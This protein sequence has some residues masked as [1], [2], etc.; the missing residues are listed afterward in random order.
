MDLLSVLTWTG[1]I[2]CLVLA[3]TGLVPVIAA[4]ATFAAIPFHAFVN[5]YRKAEP[6]LPRVAIVV[7]AWNE[8]AV[9]GASIDR[10]MQLE[11]P[12]EALRI[13]VV[14]DAST[15]ATPDV[16]REKA[17]LYPGSVVLL[18]RDKGGE[19]KAHTLNHGITEILKDDWMEALLIMDADVIYLPDSLRRM[20]RHLADPEVGAVSAY[21]REGSADRNYLTKFIAVEYVLS[22]PAVRRAQNVLGAQACLAGGAQLHTRENVLAI[23]GRID[24]SSLAEDTI[25]TFE[26]QLTGRKVVFEPMA[27]VLAEEPRAVEGLWK[28][29]LRWARGNVTVTSRY[30]NVWFRPSRTHHLGAWTFGITWF[31]LWLLPVIMIVSS[32]GLVGLLFLQSEFATTAFRI[33]WIGAALAYVFTLVLGSLTDGRTSRRS[34]GHI[35][36]FP[37]IVNTIVMLTALFPGLMLVWLP[38]LFGATLSGTTLFV[39]TLA[40]YIWIPVSMVVA[41]LARKA[42]PTRA[43]RWL[44]PTLI[45]LAGYGSLLCAITFDSYLKELS[46]A[47]AR[48]DKTEK[49]GRIATS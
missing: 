26:T 20:T 24:T 36:L 3:L 32:I 8:G 14:D 46:H 47:E 38:G 21:I 17:A 30:R 43:G 4:A 18:R 28:Q 34:I 11:Y 23:G 1:V 49:V 16:V 39:L 25:T 19:G 29:R 44:T 33:L 2:V 48:W 35:I 31:S 42:E 27:E 7:P 41:W 13:Y 22:Q 45:Y 40:I 6:Y 5:H 10:L 9:I 12:R 37:G 15:D